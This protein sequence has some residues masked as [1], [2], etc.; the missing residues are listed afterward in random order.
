[1]EIRNRMKSL[2]FFL[3]VSLIVATCGVP[4]R[5]VEQ[6]AMDSIAAEHPVVDTVVDPSMLPDP[7]FQQDMESL[8][9]IRRDSNGW[10]IK[11]PPED[12]GVDTG[13][14]HIPGK[15]SRPDL[16]DRRA[17]YDSI[18]QVVIR[19]KQLYDSLHGIKK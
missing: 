4:K 9:Y 13:P 14:R 11:P 6:V 8:R 7:D 16:P 12:K 15:G 5:T 1:M 10:P 17:F 19:Q 3:L 2:S 18:D